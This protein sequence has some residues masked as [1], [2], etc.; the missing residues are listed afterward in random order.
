M[1]LETLY[2]TVAP[3]LPH[4]EKFVVGSVDAVPLLFQ[5]TVSYPASL[6]L[7]DNRVAISFADD[8]DDGT[9]TIDVFPHPSKKSPPASFRTSLSILVLAFE[10]GLVVFGL[11]GFATD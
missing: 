10:D 9:S 2:S 11:L 8:T 5:N 7:L 6:N 3:F 1:S 4:I